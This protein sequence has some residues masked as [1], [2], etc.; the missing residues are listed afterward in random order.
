MA[1]LSD[2]LV[3]FGARP[4]ARAAASPPAPPAGATCA[5]PP[6]PDLDINA[7]VAAERAAAEAALSD[8]LARAHEEALAAERER[9]AREI[10]A[11]SAHFGTEAADMLAR[12][13]AEAEARLTEL[14]TSAAARILA[15]LVSDEVR[16][17]SIERLGAAIR[18]ALED[19]DAVRVRVFGP[20]SLFSALAGRLGDRARQLHHVEAPGLDIV[21][22]IDGELFETRLSDWSAMLAEA[23]S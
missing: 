1:A 12:R 4:R 20:Q 13:F 19:G 10:D 18:E 3:D 16:R 23:L 11:L 21:I 5:N 14:A 6:Q 8:R 2:V 17:L 22:D 9:H 15:G 7:L